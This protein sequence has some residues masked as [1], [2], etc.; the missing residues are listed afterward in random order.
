MKDMGNKSLQEIGKLSADINRKLANTNLTEALYSVS[1]QDTIK[2]LKK[3]HFIKAALRIFGAKSQKKHRVVTL[4]GA[5]KKAYYAI[6]ETDRITKDDLA[7]GTFLVSNVGNLVRGLQGDASVLMI[8]PPM[9][10]AMAVNAAQRR[11]IVVK[12]E[13]GEEKV[14]DRVFLHTAFP[15]EL[16]WE[17]ISVLDTDQIEAGIIFDLESFDE[18]TKTLLK[19]ELERKYYEPRIKTIVSLK[20]RYGFSYWEVVCTDG[21]SV[22]FTMQDTFKNI[23]RVGEDRAIL[24][25]VDG[26][27]FVIESIME[28]DKKSHKKIELYM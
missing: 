22:K 21:R 1:I 23:I 18:D 27:R 17:Y 24:L 10:C 26:N 25:D 9:V 2:A 5:E 6:P 19:N 16:L 4:K 8:I 28:L 15:F 20:E 13:N 14:Y 11:P 3:G 7:Q 12:D